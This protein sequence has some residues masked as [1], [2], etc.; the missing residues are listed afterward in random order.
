ML[1]L[2][3]DGSIQYQSATIQR[4]AT[5]IIYLSYEI[6]YVHEGFESLK[7][8][9]WTDNDSTKGGNFSIRREVID[10]VPWGRFHLCQFVFCFLHFGLGLVLLVNHGFWIC[11]VNIYR[12][13]GYRARSSWVLFVRSPWGLCH[14]FWI[15]IGR[16]RFRNSERWRSKNVNFTPSANSSVARKGS[17][18][19]VGKDEGL[20]IA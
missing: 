7:Y 13:L 2:Q 18:K 6:C 14:F 1:P 17:E 9:C 10:R 8:R 4:I 16:V 11:G 5:K 20:S 12:G 15:S 19:V 3:Q